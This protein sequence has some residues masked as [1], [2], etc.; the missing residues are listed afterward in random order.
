[1]IVFVLYYGLLIVHYVFHY[2]KVVC[3]FDS[4]LSRHFDTNSSF[5]NN[6]K[7]ISL[8]SIVADEITLF[9]H[10]KLNAPVY[11]EG[12]ILAFLLEK[13]LKELV[14]LLKILIHDDQI[15]IRTH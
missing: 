2:F 8:F 5:K 3:A 4:G 10:L 15:G 9:A 14:G 11:T 7:F 6:I 12:I 13:V 1:M